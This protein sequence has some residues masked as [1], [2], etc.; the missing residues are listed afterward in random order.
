MKLLFSFLSIIYL[1]TSVATAKESTPELS[2]K[3]SAG[4]LS[5]HIECYGS[6]TA[7][8]IVVN[9]GYNGYGS[10]GK[11]NQVINDV[12]SKHRIC[13]YD[14]A[15]MGKSDRITEPYNYKNSA[16]RLKKLLTN[17]GVKPPYIMVGHSKGSYPVRFYNGLFP[18]EVKGI[19]LVDPSQYGQDYNMVAKWKPDLEDYSESINEQRLLELEVFNNPKNTTYNPFMIDLK[20]NELELKKTSKFGSVPFVLLW[21]KDGH[22]IGSKP[23]KDWHPDVWFRMAAMYKLAIE[24]MH[25]GMSTDT[26]IVYSKTSE[27]DIFFVE[28]QAVVK[29]IELLSSKVLQKH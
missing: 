2:G 7:I 17:A 21:A 12:K 24:N 9:S 20:E 11:W 27:H 29:Q 3:F 26:T 13:V 14:R 22:S 10:Q 16:V 15:G 25:T 8:S 28:P 19:L 5:L 18:D 4:D 6:P 1:T 23:S